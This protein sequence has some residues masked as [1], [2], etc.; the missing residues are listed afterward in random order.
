[1]I[2]RDD[3]PG[4]TT[5]ASSLGGMRTPLGLPSMG[6]GAANLQ[7][8][9]GP[10]RAGSQHSRHGLAGSSRGH[11]PSRSPEREGPSK[12]VPDGSPTSS[13]GR[14]QQGSLSFSIAQ[15][16]AELKDRG[17]EVPELVEEVVTQAPQQGTSPL[18]PVHQR[19]GAVTRVG[20]APGVSVLAHGSIADRTSPR[21]KAAIPKA[22]GV[23]PGMGSLLSKARVVPTSGLHQA[24]GVPG[25]SRVVRTGTRPAMPPQGIAM[26]RSAGQIFPSSTR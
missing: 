17:R 22:N 13:V 15:P 26:A 18:S 1:M 3:G 14:A 25:G 11:Q 19:P 2:S 5:P 8:T 7:G 6:L 10:S 16:R 9:S 24:C 12:D 23:Q 20:S 4:V 21:V